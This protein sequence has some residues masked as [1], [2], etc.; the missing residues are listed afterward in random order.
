[1]NLT[2]N[3]YD[4]ENTTITKA[5]N[6]EI[7]INPKFYGNQSLDNLIDL[8]LRVHNVLNVANP[9]SLTSRPPRK[10]TPTYPMES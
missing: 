6:S 1:M 10:K 7:K 3:K 8:K 2:E 5:S 9:I 4:D